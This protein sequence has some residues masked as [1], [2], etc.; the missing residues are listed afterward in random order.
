VDR[1]AV[2]QAGREASA[3]ESTVE[4]LAGAEDGYDHQVVRNARLY[5]AAICIAAVLLVVAII[6]I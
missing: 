3:S 4:M 1:E 5:L 6:A 2:I